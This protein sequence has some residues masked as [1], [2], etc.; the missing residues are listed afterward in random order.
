M[1][2]ESKKLVREVSAFVQM[3]FQICISLC[4]VLV[5]YLVWNTDVEY[6]KNQESIA[7]IDRSLKLD[8]VLSEM[9]E[10]VKSVREKINETSQMET[11]LG[12]R[13]VILF[14]PESSPKERKIAIDLSQGLLNKLSEDYDKISHQIS[15]LR[16]KYGI[17][18]PVLQQQFS[19]LSNPLM[20]APTE[21]YK[22][23]ER[24]MTK[25]QEDIISLTM[26]EH[27]LEHNGI[28]LLLIA[29]EHINACEQFKIES[30][31]F[32]LGKN[33]PVFSSLEMIT[34]VNGALLQQYADLSFSPN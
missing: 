15:Y 1:N 30:F 14:N 8:L 10:T 25:M 19:G 34:R 31:N 20:T 23:W 13:Y 21:D 9:Y 2:E 7:L 16:M 12:Y 17:Y 18:F 33:V 6:K 24:L 28:D 32:P 11:Y 27:C 29:N 5:S 4:A 22:A 3:I 26:L